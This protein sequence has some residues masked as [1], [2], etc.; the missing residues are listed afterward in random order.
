[1]KKIG[2]LLSFCLLRLIA[3][4]P[5]GLIARLG[6]FLGSVLY[7]LPGK[8]KHIVHTNLRLCFPDLAPEAREKLARSNFRQVIRSYVERSF[9]W[10][11]SSRRLERLIQVESAIEL[12]TALPPSLFLGFHFIGLEASLVLSARYGQPA[13]S[14]YTPMSN[15]WFEALAKRQRERFNGIFIPRSNSVREILKLLRQNQSIMLAAD[16]DHGH[17]DSAFVPFFGIPA[18]TLTSVSKIAKIANVQVVPFI[19]EI[20]PHYQGYKI[21]IFEPFQNYPSDDPSADALLMNR[22]L[23]KEILRLPDQYYWVHRRFKTRPDGESPVY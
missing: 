20:L 8:R 5:Y 12:N 2:F 13:A 6:N 19:T 14:L 17:R 15:P 7:L 10:F 9:L 22:F 21:K 11:A 23:E 4:L 18:C 16:M 3:L 1:M